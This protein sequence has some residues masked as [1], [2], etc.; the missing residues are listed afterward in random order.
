M[1]FGDNRTK[2]PHIQNV[3][4]DDILNIDGYSFK[5][6]DKWKLVSHLHKS[7]RHGKPFDAAQA[8]KWI[9]TLDSAY[10]RYRLAVIAF[11]DVAGGSP[12]II[13][14]SM[15]NGWK[16][17]NIEAQGGVEWFSEQ[18]K[19]W[20]ESIKDRIANDWCSCGRWLG[21]FLKKYNIQKLDDLS[22]EKCADIA[23]NTE[24]S[25]QERG[26]AAWR[27]AGT[28]NFPNSI[29]GK[30]NGDWDYWIK[31][32]EDN[33]VSENVIDCTI[34]GLATQKEGSPIFLPFVDIAQRNEN[35]IKTN[36]KFIDLPK[37]GPY[38]SSS[39]D[40]HTSEGKQ[41]V[42][43]YIRNN[44]RLLS[45]MK[46]NN[47]SFEMASEMLG[48]IQFWFEGGVLNKTLKYSTSQKINNDIRASFIS[49]FNIN[50]KD[51][52]KYIDDYQNWHKA[53]KYILEK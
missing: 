5:K 22:I 31:L 23:W 14:E 20:S 3:I 34:K 24:L 11:E 9:Y 18:A 47:I 45:F 32:C 43:Y 25:W 30:F 8:A 13:S 46:E 4:P 6:E 51:F 39:L 2:I 52:Y 26:L 17:E 44:Q 38:A 10:A 40:K 37:I 16:K 28:K 36:L 12:D 1:A 15:K 48:R 21:A 19:I 42:S 50:P 7:I 41:A 29:L 27:I 53:R 49:D 33:K 35:A